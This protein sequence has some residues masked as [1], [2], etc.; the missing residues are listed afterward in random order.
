MIGA[1]EL[2]TQHVRLLIEHFPSIRNLMIFDLA[3]SRALSLANLADALAGHVFTTAVATAEEAARSADV[4]VTATTAV[5]GYIPLS[6]LK[7]DSV[8]INVSL[9]D[10]LPEVYFGAE[11]LVVDDW[12]LITSDPYRLLGKLAREGRV[13]GP[14]ADIQ[15][16]PGEPRRVYAELGSIANGSVSVP[17]AD[18]IVLVNPF[19]MAINDVALATAV[20]QEAVRTGRGTTIDL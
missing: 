4:L 18:G 2:G 3:Y 7:C 1:G 14:T 9:D 15:A 8:L 6:W 13:Q 10:L 19:G 12:H 17:P 20:H 16:G 11:V 5:E